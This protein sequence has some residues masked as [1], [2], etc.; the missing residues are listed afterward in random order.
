MFVTAVC[1]LFL[2]AIYIVEGDRGRN[3]GSDR[4][5]KSTRGGE[6]E[7]RR[8]NTQGGGSQEKWEI[9]FATLLNFFAI[10]KSAQRRKPLRKGAETGRTRNGKREIQTPCPSIYQSIN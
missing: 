10:E 2:K 1:V 5:R 4:S 9:H 3:P 8:R 6:R 7:G